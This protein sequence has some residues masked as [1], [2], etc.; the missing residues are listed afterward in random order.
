MFTPS[1]PFHHV[2]WRDIWSPSCLNFIMFWP[3]GECLVYNSTSLP[4]LLIIFPNFFH[5]TLY[6][7]RITP[8]F[9]YMHPSMCVHTSHRPYGYPPFMLCSWQ[10]MHWNPWCNSWHLC[11]HWAKCWLPCVT[12]TITCTSFNHIQL[13]SSMNWHCAYQ[14]RHSHF[15]Q[16]CHCWPNASGFTSLILH[17]SKIYYLW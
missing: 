5:N 15:N 1:Y 8:S 4:N 3:R 16:R 17:N 10:W 14:R 2:F 13:L 9:N 6:A 12:R 11:C 7:I